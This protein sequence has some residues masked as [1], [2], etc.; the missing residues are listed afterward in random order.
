[1]G[2]HRFVSRNKDDNKVGLSIEDKQLIQV[3]EKSLHKDADGN[4]VAPLP[5]GENRPPLPNNRL[6]TLNRTK[7]LHASLSKDPVKLQHIVT[8]MQRVFD[9]KHAEVAPPLGSNEKCRY[10]PL[11]GVYHPQ[12]RGQIRG[13]FDSSAQFQRLSLNSVLLSG[14]DLTNNLVHVLLRFRMETYNKCSTVSLSRKNTEIS[15]DSCGMET[16]ILTT[17]L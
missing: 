3:M 2:Q 15:L 8:F 17:V 14:P 16:M 12:K 5:F 6:Q 11:F 9:S 1:M 4:W 13:V 7:N 10:L